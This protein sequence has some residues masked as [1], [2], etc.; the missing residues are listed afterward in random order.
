MRQIVGM[1]GPRGSGKDTC[2]AVLVSE[3]GFERVAFADKLYRETAEAFGVTVMFLGNRSTKETD[4]ERLALRH[5]KDAHFVEV[6]LSAA[7]HDV[8]LRKG[9]LKLHTH[10]VG[11]A[12]V[13]IRRMKTLL[14]KA[15]SPRLTMQ[16]WGTEY[17]RR[18]KYGLDSYWLDQVSAVIHAR[19]DRSFVITDVR[20][21]N[22]GDFVE[23]QGGVLVRVRRKEIEARDAA[24]RQASGLALHPSETEMLS[25]PVVFEIENK[26]GQFD[27]LKTQVLAV[28]SQPRPLAA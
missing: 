25:R 27:D 13:S 19:P 23:R 18:S 2:A 28:V 10:G 7:T 9:A 6:A 24:E 4:L 21:H 1:L 8:A 26:E 5:C 15:R 17:R 16:Q 3:A 20:F 12:G 14:K 22:E 11:P